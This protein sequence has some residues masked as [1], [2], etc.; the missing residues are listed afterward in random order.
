V[1]H[2][3]I[4]YE[5]VLKKITVTNGLTGLGIE[6]IVGRKKDEAVFFFGSFL[7]DKQKK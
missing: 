4:W 6:P 3:F 2:G 5:S 7:L 1:S